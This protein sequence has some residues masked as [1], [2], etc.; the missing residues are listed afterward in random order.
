M[1]TDIYDA[2]T[3]ND[4][5]RCQI[6]VPYSRFQNSLSVARAS[7][8][9]GLTPALMTVYELLKPVMDISIGYQFSKNNIYYDAKQTSQK[10][11]KAFYNIGS[12]C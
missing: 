7:G 3:I 1:T 4:T 6:T 10:H 8:Y 11:M 2:D 12:F 5:I 9:R